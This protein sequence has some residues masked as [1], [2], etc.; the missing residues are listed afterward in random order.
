MMQRVNVRGAPTNVVFPMYPPPA[1]KVW[2]TTSE[3]VTIPVTAGQRE[4]AL[5][6]LVEQGMTRPMQYDDPDVPSNMLSALPPDPASTASAEAAAKA[7]GLF[8]IL[9]CD[10]APHIATAKYAPRSKVVTVSPM[11]A[12]CRLFC[13]GALVCLCFWTSATLV[14]E[15]EGPIVVPVETPQGLAAVNDPVHR[16][17]PPTLIGLTWCI[18]AADCRARGVCCRCDHPVDI[19]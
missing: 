9:R 12:I 16:V 4:I 6:N 7:P 14:D 17:P 15:N 10:P 3:G 8:A 18:C 5:R 13:G 1:G 11:C 19:R 2:Y